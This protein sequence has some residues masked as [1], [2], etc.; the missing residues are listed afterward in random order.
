MNKKIVGRHPVGR[1]PVTAIFDIGKTNKK[2]FFFD[3]E[4]D[5][6][7]PRWTA[8]RIVFESNSEFE[9]IL[10]EDG[11]PCEDIDKLSNWVINS[12]KVA[13]NHP[14]F[15]VKAVNFATYGASFV[16]VDEN[17]VPVAPLYNYLKP[18]PED[19][20][21]LFYQK[22][23][24]E[25]KIARETA[26]PILGNLNSGMQLFRLKYQKLL[27]GNPLGGNPQIFKRVKYALHLPQYMSSLI[28]KQFFSELTSIGC[29]TQLWDFEKNDYHEWV[30]SEGID[31]ILAP[32]VPTDTIIETVV[33]GKKIKVGIGLHDSSAALIPYLLREKR[34]AVQRVAV[35]EPFVL[36]STGTWCISLNPFNSSPLTDEELS[37][38]CLCFMTFEG[39]IVKASRL[40]AGNKHH[41][42]TKKI[43]AH[44]GVNEDFY[45]NIVFD[46]D[47]LAAIRT[48]KDAAFD[49]EIM[50]YH[51]LMLEIVNEQVASTNLV[52]YNTDKSV[53]PIKT[54][55]IDGG[56][57]KNSIYIELLKLSFPEMTITVASVNQATAIG[58]ALVMDC[59][60]LPSSRK[61]VK[62]NK[63]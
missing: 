43:A 20:K 56:F 25:Q 21:T 48:T 30:K 27:D 3:E 13:L 15:E 38:D 29:H 59:H 8:P 55:Y 44:F 26:S 16:L 14:V 32:I 53:P 37:K 52:I 61:N 9:E 63:K 40:F 4:Y 36:I 5:W 33:E 31:T 62:R 42:E 58:A 19:L 1:Q 7:A 12:L 18:F 17:G 28:T 23:G 47:I 10:D 11:D 2:L 57:S 39:K 45:K 34:N 50:A 41:T 60:G 54:I 51:Q 22:Y 46:K 49:N 6:T 24:G 35:Q